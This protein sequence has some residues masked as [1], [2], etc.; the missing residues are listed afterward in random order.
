MDEYKFFSTTFTIFFSHSRL[1]HTF[2]IVFSLLL[3][4]QKIVSYR[5]F[6]KLSL[7]I[8]SYQPRL[9]MY[10]LCKNNDN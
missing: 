1:N 10:S 5:C 8:V 2:I 3:F 4:I 7:F 9:V 6:N